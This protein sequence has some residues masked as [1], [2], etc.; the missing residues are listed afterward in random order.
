[1]LWVMKFYNSHPY[2]ELD[3]EIDFEDHRN[4][5]LPDLYPKPKT[6]IEKQALELWPDQ[7]E[8]WINGQSFGRPRTIKWPQVLNVV[9]HSVRQLSEGFDPMAPGCDG[10]FWQRMHAVDSLPYARVLT[11]RTKASHKKGIFPA[12]EWQ[13]DYEEDPFE[14]YEPFWICGG[15]L[16]K[17]VSDV[18][19]IGRVPEALREYLNSTLQKYIEK[20][21]EEDANQEA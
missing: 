17:K 10:V 5:Y 8:R 12:G 1:M 15:Y 16:P 20:K 6:Q 2:A 9:Y 11:S 3:F 7:Y 19:N 21:R 18:R 13:F 4:L 14:D